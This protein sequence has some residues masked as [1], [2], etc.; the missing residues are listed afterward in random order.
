MDSF[1]ELKLDALF[2]DADRLI[3]ERKYTDAINML[4]AILI[5][6]P[7]YGKAYNHLGFIYE[8]KYRDIAKAE[9]FYKKALLYSPNYPAVY[10]NLSVVLSSQGKYDELEPLLKQALEIKGV[11]KAG[12][13]NEFGIMYELQGKYLRAIESYKDAIRNSLSDVNVETYSKSMKRCKSKLEILE[14]N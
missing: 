12:I 13:Y 3:S 11:E 14:G 8:T 2:F 4:E 5:E 10:S 1:Q 6:A 9:E 7:D